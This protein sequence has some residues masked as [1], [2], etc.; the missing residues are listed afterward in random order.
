MIEQISGITAGVVKPIANVANNLVNKI[1]SAVGTVYEPFHLRQMAKA[2]NDANYIIETG[3]L[4]TE[5][6]KRTLQRLIAEET[7]KQENLESIID[8]AMQRLNESAKP[9]EIENDWLTHLTDLAKKV[10]DKEMQILWAKILAGEAN[11]HG[12]FSKRTLNLL[13][14]MDR[15]D[16]ELFGQLCR[17]YVKSLGFVLIYNI[18]DSV[19]NKNGINYSNLIHLES[20]GLINFNVIGQNTTSPMKSKFRI[21]YGNTTFYLDRSDNLN[22]IEFNVGHVILTNVGM[23]LLGLSNAEMEPEFTDYLEKIFISFGFSVERSIIS[24]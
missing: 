13:S 14:A 12:S 8:E 10:S 20:I 1:S 9:E 7:K 2:K 6:E 22:E 5:L 4:K 21:I 17:Y 15:S 16:A 18:R 11:A 3:A 24:S 23:Q 19:Y